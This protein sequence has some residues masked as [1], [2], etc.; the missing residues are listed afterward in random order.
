M[1]HESEIELPQIEY[2]TSEVLRI[3]PHTN[4]GHVGVD[5]Y[6]SIHSKDPGFTTYSHPK[7]KFNFTVEIEMRRNPIRGD[8]FVG[9]PTMEL[10]DI[11]LKT[12][13]RPSPSVQYQDI[14]YYN[15]RTKVATSIDWGTCSLTFYDDADD[16]VQDIYRTYLE[17]I[18]PVSR[19]PPG[20]MNLLD[21]IESVP[22]GN[23]SSLG[24]LPTG[25]QNGLIRSIRLHH[26]Y[27][28]GNVLKRTTYSYMNPKV[29]S[30]EFDELSMTESNVNNLTLNFHYDGVNTSTSVVE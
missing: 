19:I 5:P 16:R 3:T 23:L 21:A 12:A 7:L 11:P 13:T 24:E 22:F 1:P 14:N 17:A 26:F 4:A 8:Y 28:S 10:L 2:S 15:Y 6:K 29:S 30:F 20:S 9:A 25:A 27:S 18:S